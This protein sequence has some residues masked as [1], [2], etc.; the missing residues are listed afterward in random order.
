MFSLSPQ[1]V[2][3]LCFFS[4]VIS[5]DGSTANLV[6]YWIGTE[7]CID[8]C[9]TIDDHC[10][11]TA[12]ASFELL[13]NGTGKYATG[14]PSGVVTTTFNDNFASGKIIDEVASTIHGE[15]IIEANE[16]DAWG[17]WISFGTERQFHWNFKRAPPS[18]SAFELSEVFAAGMYGY[19]CHRVPALVS[20]LDSMG[21]NVLVM[22]V[23][24]RRTSCADQAP[25]DINLRRSLDG[26]KTWSEPVRVMGT[27]METLNNETYRNPYPTVCKGCGPQRQDVV[28]VNFVNSTLAT[29]WV[30]FQRMSL[31]AGL[32]WTPAQMV[33]GLDPSSIEGILGGPGNGIELGLRSNKPVRAGRLVSCGAT[34]YHGGVAMETAVWF[35]DDN[36][37]TWSVAKTALPNMQ[38]CQIAELANGTLLLNMRNAHLNPCDCRATSISKDGG[39]TWSDVVYVSDLIEPVLSAGFINTGNGDTD[40]LYFSN[41]ASKTER[42]NMTIKYSA[43]SGAQWNSGAVVWAGPAAYSV[44]HDLNS[45]HVCLG[46]EH[47]VL[48]P[49]ELVSVAFVPKSKIQVFN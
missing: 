46:F 1:A 28:I 25:K 29:P 8:H 49:Y 39:D 36:G 11:G 14:G 26:G 9:C 4:H 30:S 43:D 3:L 41:A 21:R 19:S 2:V 17:S 12:Q 18:G 15:F 34:G 42:H 16:T 7:T 6:G 27:S 20:A 47:G 24:S 22:F 44:L 45:T 31:D 5:A 40:E 48:S 23:E 13:A 32:T 38:E 37:T 10:Q 35:S 33:K